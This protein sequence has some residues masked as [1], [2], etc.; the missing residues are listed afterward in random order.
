[1]NK[2]IV[3]DKTIGKVRAEVKNT[4]KT[5]DTVKMDTVRDKSMVKKKNNTIA[6]TVDKNKNIN[7]IKDMEKMDTARDR[8]MDKIKD[9]MKDKAKDV[10]KDMVRTISKTR[11]RTKGTEK[12]VMAKDKN[13]GLPLLTALLMAVAPPLLMAQ[14]RLLLLIQKPRPL[15]MAQ[16]TLP[17]GKAKITAVIS[18][19]LLMILDPL[20]L[21]LLM[22]PVAHPTL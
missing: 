22:M 17:V 6:K 8:F 20:Q 3:K 2:I 21:V 19:R 12:M 14:L 16:L 15:A 10:T 11:D 13:M 5:K 7:K 4:V 18:N 9:K 1:M